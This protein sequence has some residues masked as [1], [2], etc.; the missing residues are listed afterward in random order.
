MRCVRDA[1]VVREGA[2][3]RYRV[4]AAGCTYLCARCRLAGAQQPPE[5]STYEFPRLK[6]LFQRWKAVE[7]QTNR[8]D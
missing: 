3:Y 6:L 7:S 5:P 4:D 8:V 1:K 2:H